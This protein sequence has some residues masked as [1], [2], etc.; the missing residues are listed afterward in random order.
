MHHVNHGDAERIASSIQT[1]HAAIDEA[2][3]NFVQ[4]T[5][6]MLDAG[7]GSDIPAAASQ[8]ALEA[9]TMAIT[10]MCNARRDF[11]SAHRHMV[12]LKGESD[13]REVG[14]G[15]LGDGPIT[16]GSANLRI[17]A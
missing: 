1:T 12:A 10:N 6:T 13:L 11:V 3:L 17:A 8:K 7:R 9:A 4:L 15:C 5:G 16:T 14:F 2:M